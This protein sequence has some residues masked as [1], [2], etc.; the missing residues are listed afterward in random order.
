MS[1]SSSIIIKLFFCF[2][3]EISSVCYVSFLFCSVCVCVCV[4]AR[5]RICRV[6]ACA[7]CECRSPKQKRNDNGMKKKKTK[8]IYSKTKQNFFTRSRRIRGKIGKNFKNFSSTPRIVLCTRKNFRIFPFSIFLFFLFQPFFYCCVCVLNK[9]TPWIV[10]D[11]G[12][13]RR[14]RRSWT[15]IPRLYK[16][17]M[18]QLLIM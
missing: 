10:H 6:F 2:L 17:S 12:K 14:R 5:A 18:A 1:V 13:R 15:G 4:C 16:K 9:T 3:E 8:R 7:C 11:I